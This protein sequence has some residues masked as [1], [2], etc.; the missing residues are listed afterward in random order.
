MTESDCGSR[1]SKSVCRTTLPDSGLKKYFF[2][3]FIYL[4]VSCR[5]AKGNRRQRLRQM[6]AGME[7][8]GATA[9]VEVTRE[10]VMTGSVSG[11]LA[12]SLENDIPDSDACPRTRQELMHVS[13][14][15]ACES[16]ILPKGQGAG[17][18]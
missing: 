6:F 5:T 2:H 17:Y 14:V 11:S 16:V 12:F 8:V 15:A 4:D 7:V 10:G 9:D 1:P 18:S 3:L 13:T